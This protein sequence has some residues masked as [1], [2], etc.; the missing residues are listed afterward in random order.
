MRPLSK[1]PKLKLPDPWTWNNAPGRFVSTAPPCNAKLPEP[2]QRA[3]PRFSSVRVSSTALEFATLRMAP[4]PITVRPLP[5]IVPELHTKVPTTVSVPLPVSVGLLPAPPSVRSAHRAGVSSVTV[6]LPG[7]MTVS[8]VPGARLGDQLFPTFQSPFAAFVQIKD[9]GV[10]RANKVL[11]LVI[12]TVT[13]LL[14]VRTSPD[15]A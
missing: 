6:L 4:A 2:V 1:P 9:I 15:Q 3:V 14:R 11:L 7:M 13:E 12:T 10:K 8:F 5:P